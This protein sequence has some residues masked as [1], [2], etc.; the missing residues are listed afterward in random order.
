MFVNF[1]R[2]GSDPRAQLR[3]PRPSFIS[4]SIS[5]PAVAESSQQS[6]QTFIS[7]DNPFHFPNILKQT[8]S[9]TEKR[10][11]F[12]GHSLCVMLPHNCFRILD[13]YRSIN[14]QQKVILD[15]LWISYQRKNSGHFTNSLNAL[16]DYFNGLNNLSKFECYAVFHG[17]PGNAGLYKTWVE[18]L[19]A[20]RGVKHPKYKGFKTITEGFEA[21]RF[22][23]GNQ[24]HISDQINTRPVIQTDKGN[25][26]NFCDHCETLVKNFRIINEKYKTLEQEFSDNKTII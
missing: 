25:Q 5:K 12:N 23:L 22:Y 21:C 11:D 2:P 18:V 9:G 19:T 6:H 24:F 14:E 26:I 20:I 4:S 8:P 17:T 10:Y 3:A 7:L 1:Y 13:T 15:N 16:S